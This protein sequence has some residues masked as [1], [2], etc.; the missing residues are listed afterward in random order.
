VVRGVNGIFVWC[1]VVR[2][3]WCVV[4]HGI[5]GING[6]RCGG[7]G[8]QKSFCSVLWWLSYFNGFLW[9]IGADGVG[10]VGMISSFPAS[11]AQFNQL[12]H[13]LNVICAKISKNPIFAE[14]RF[15]L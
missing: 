12:K 3:L 2:C 1:C 9:C 14:N 6:V 4:V 10:R 5:S 13:W 11:P 8:M 7:C 15:F